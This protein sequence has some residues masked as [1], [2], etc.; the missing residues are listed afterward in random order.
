MA[1]LLHAMRNQRDHLHLRMRI[2]G[3]VTRDV[4][5]LEKQ[6]DGEKTKHDRCR[7]MSC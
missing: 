7:G 5:D 3:A 2:Q 4:E 6:A 1:L